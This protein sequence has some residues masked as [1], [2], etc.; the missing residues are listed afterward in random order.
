MKTVNEILDFPKFE[1]GRVQL[2][3]EPFSLR[4]CAEDAAKTFLGTAQQKG[5]EMECEVITE[6]KRLTQSS[7]MPIG[8]AR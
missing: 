8:S 3:Q 5:L 2:E 4:K 6:E 7:A 1:A